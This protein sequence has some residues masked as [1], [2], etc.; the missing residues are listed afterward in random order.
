MTKNRKQLLRF[1]F[2]QNE[3]NELALDQ[4]HDDLNETRIAP[5]WVEVDDSGR[6]HT[7]DLSLKNVDLTD[8][9]TSEA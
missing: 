5:P 9:E 3:I 4:Q 6:L 2:D 8:N 7:V 1:E